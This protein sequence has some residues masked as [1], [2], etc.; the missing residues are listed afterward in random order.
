MTSILLAHFLVAIAKVESG[1]NDHAIGKAG[2]VSRYQILPAVWKHH[3]KMSLK[4]AVNPDMAKVVA[5]DYLNCE[6]DWFKSA[7][8]REPNFTEMTMLWHAP[9]RIQWPSLD[10]KDY[11]QRVWNLFRVEV[12]REKVK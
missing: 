1:E 5:L 3:T 9:H 11:C 6:I 4:D 8:G 10:D 7:N 12:D 2:E